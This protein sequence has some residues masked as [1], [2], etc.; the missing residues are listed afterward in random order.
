MQREK[1]FDDTELDIV[2]N[3]NFKAPFPF[4]E[5]LLKTKK[6]DLLIKSFKIIL[7]LS[8]KKEISR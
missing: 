7:D 8:L 4:D 2:S 1:E 6:K 3:S 5:P